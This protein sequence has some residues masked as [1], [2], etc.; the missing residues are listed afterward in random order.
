M[1]KMEWPRITPMNTDKNKLVSIRA[2]PG[3]STADLFG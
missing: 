3:L 1:L 2:Y